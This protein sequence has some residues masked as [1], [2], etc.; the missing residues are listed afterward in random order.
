MRTTSRRT[1]PPRGNFEER[2]KISA[3]V[4]DVTTPDARYNGE[5]PKKKLEN[6]EKDQKNSN[7]SKNLQNMQIVKST[8]GGFICVV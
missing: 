4:K 3:L 7:T 2:L 6:K 8:G 1:Q 5:M